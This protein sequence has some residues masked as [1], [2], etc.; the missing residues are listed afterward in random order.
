MFETNDMRSMLYRIVLLCL[1]IGHTGVFVYADSP[2][3]PAFTSNNAAPID[4]VIDDIQVTGI[5][6][7]DKE[8][9]L[10]FLGFNIGDIIRM[11]GLATRDAMSINN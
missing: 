6:T 5:T 3:S 8:A 2:S 9:V 1:F 10:A 4:Y 7:L 11:P